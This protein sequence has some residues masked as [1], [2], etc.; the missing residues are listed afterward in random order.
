VTFEP[1]LRWDV[2]DVGRIR[3]LGRQNIDLDLSKQ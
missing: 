2:M 3:C 1:E